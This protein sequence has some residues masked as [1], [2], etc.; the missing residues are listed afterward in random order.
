MW[1]FGAWVIILLLTSGIAGYMEGPPTGVHQWRQTDGASMALNYFQNDQAFFS[2]QEHNLTGADGHSASE[3][4][5]IN[6]IVGKIYHITGPQEIIFR[7]AN[8]LF[9]I[10]GLWF[11]FKTGLHCTRSP[12]AAMVPV[13]IFSASPVYFYYGFHFLPN[14][15]AISCALAG[16]Y[17]FITGANSYLKYR[18]AGAMILFGLGA[19]LKISDGISLAAAGMLLILEFV[20]RKNKAPTVFITGLI[21]GLIAVSAVAAWT[22]FTIRY[23]AANHTS[24]SL[25]GILPIWQMDAASIAATCSRFWSEWSKHIFHPAIWM[26]HGVALLLF[27]VEYRRL[28]QQLRLITMLLFGGSILYIL[29]WMEPMYHHDYYMLTPLISLIFMWLTVMERTMSMLERRLMGGVS[30]I[31]ISLVYI[32]FSLF[33]LWYNRGMQLYRS[34]DSKYENVAAGFYTIEPYLRSLGIERTDRVISAGDPT[35]NV[36]LYLMN[37]P[38]WTDVYNERKVTLEEMLAQGAKYL[39][40]SG[41]PMKQNATIQPDLYEP[42]GEYM[43]IR[44]YRLRP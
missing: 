17:Y 24:L 23:N 35:R 7:I 36:S 26:L 25:T 16:W 2:P 41:P 21:A 6:F 12:W 8:G 39:V 30:K 43:G 40:V 31:A 44:I 18:I 5:L 38:G 14:V 29:L 19:L 11:L 27:I 20:H 42:I 4:P 15:P 32:L 34:T 22:I 3:F 9:L 13:I 1:L 37:N 33:V 10:I 28:N